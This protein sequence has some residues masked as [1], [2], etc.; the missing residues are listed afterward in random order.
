MRSARPQG[1]RFERA[2][3]GVLDSGRSQ[4]ALDFTQYD[5]QNRHCR[6]FE[7]PLSRR[8]L[9]GVGVATGLAAHAL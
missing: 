1:S 7:H 3:L 2:R 5:A 9:L 8:K 6:F 4:L